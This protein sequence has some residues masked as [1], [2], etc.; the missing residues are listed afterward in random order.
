MHLLLQRLAHIAGKAKGVRVHG[1]GIQQA[2][3]LFIKIFKYLLAQAALFRRLLQQLL[4]VEGNT[5][6]LGNA[7][8]DFLAAAAELSPNSNDGFHKFS[9]LFFAFAD[10]HLCQR[11]WM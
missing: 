10:S 6:L 11:T 1:D 2:L 8:T 5:Q 9:S 7:D 3:G 4:I